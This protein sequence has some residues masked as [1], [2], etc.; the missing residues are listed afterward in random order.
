MTD[1]KSNFVKAFH[2]NREILPRISA[3]YELNIMVK[4]NYEN[5]VKYIVVVA[6]SKIAHTFFATFVLDSL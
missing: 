3:F 4:A 2:Q 5:T 6:F 1:Q